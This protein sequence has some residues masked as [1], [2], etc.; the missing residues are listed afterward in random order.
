MQSKEELEELLDRIPE[1]LK[2]KQNQEVSLHIGTHTYLHFQG[3][4]LE[5]EKKN[6]S[7]EQTGNK[8][9]NMI[10]NLQVVD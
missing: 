8:S 10:K 3:E 9:F 6:I 2:K 1:S 4:M 7:M 5:V